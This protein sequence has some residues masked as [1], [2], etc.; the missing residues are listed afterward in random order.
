MPSSSNRTTVDWGSF[1][2]LTP[3][4]DN[5]SIIGASQGVPGS[6]KTHFWFTAPAPIA[7][8]RFDPGGEKGLSSNELFRDKEIW[9]RDYCGDLN[10]GKLDAEERINRSLEVMGHFQEDWDVAIRNARTLIIDKEQMLWEMLRY[11]HDEVASPTPKNFHELNMMYRGWIQDAEVN[12]RNL[13]LIRDEH[14]TWGKT[15]FSEK[16]GKAQ[17]GF[18]GIY[19]PDGQKYVPG[20]V[21]INLIH[22]W[23]EA[24]G[25]FQVKIGDKCRLGPAVSLMGKEFPSLDFPTLGTLLYP[26]SDASE[27]E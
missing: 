27:W 20:L 6:G 3:D 14:D 2:Q 9:M 10:I 8:F 25:E 7:Y 23:D 21:Q 4:D 15:G 17:Y 13:G 24:A 16:T 18:T 26:Q 5:R 12:Q 1:Q 22:R 11:A 19:K